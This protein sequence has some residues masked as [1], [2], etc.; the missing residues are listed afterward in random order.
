VATHPGPRLGAVAAEV[1][2]AWI[3]DGVP[4]SDLA[5]LARVHSTLV[6]VKAAL[7]D[8]GVATNDLLDAGQ[9]RRTTVRALLAWIELA[10]GPE[11]IPRRVLLE[12]IRRPGR[13]L[14]T[15]ARE[16]L[17]RPHFSL[18]DLETLGAELEGRRAA[19]WAD[20]L[21]DAATAV[22]LAEIADA[23]R[24]VA[25]VVETIGLGRTAGTLD[26]GRTN[27]ARSGHVDDLVAV[28]RAAALHPE[29]TDF[30]GWLRA[31]LGRPSTAEGVTLSSIHRVKGMEWRRVVVFGVDRDAMPHRLSGDLEEERRILHVAITRGI[32]EVVV[33]ADADRPS[34]FL[35][36]L[37]GTAPPPADE[38]TSPTKSVEKGA[39][40]R[41]IGGYEG[42]I[43]EVGVG[44][45]TVALDTGAEVV[46]GVEEILGEAGV[47]EHLA[48]RLRIWRLET[49]RRLGVPAYVVFDDRTLEAI[50]TLRPTDER[51]LLAVPGIGPRRL[52]DYGDEILGIVA[53]TG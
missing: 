37:A 24:L 34:P 12:T 5:V 28:R 44:T 15:V 20:Y 29:L 3:A 11:R 48:E 40:V 39:T 26:A 8:R 2:G 17:D 7:V 50:A 25:H 22:R 19:R 36:E 1:I 10:L 30:I 14:T 9:L 49:S 35:A 13:G 6:P 52:E 27:A 45:V 31:A 47:D 23:E 43:V 42:T 21:A 18:S 16:L 32:E 33:L 41:L 38:G 46:A 53:E 4:P 51:S